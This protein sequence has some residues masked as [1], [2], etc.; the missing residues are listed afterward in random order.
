MQKK[1]LRRLAKT[2]YGEELKKYAYELDNKIRALQA[3]G[4][5]IIWI[6]DNR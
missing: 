1:G 5:K 4:T 3:N 2:P 6:T